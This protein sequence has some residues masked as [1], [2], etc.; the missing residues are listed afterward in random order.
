MHLKHTDEYD[1]TD[2]CPDSIQIGGK[3][4]FDEG[5]EKWKI[6]QK[7]MKPTW[8]WIKEDEE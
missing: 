4:E 2:A 3:K 7:K 5:Y 8:R 1:V 6:K